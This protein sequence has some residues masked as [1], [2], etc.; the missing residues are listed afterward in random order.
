MSK[1]QIEEWAKPKRRFHCF[2]LSY[3]PIE[4]VI[5][6]T[7]IEAMTSKQPSIEQ[8]C[9][10]ASE[11]E[12]KIAGIRIDGAAA[13]AAAEDDVIGPTDTAQRTD[14]CGSSSSKSDCDD[15]IGSSIPPGFNDIDHIFHIDFMRSMQSLV[16]QQEKR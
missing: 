12:E 7:P 3:S 16:S 15:E 14:N 8:N 2:I 11:L 4:Y 10:D 6:D 13:V 5:M 9:N 1:I